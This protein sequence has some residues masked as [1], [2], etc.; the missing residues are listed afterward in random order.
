[1][2]LK[3][4]SWVASS[5]SIFGI[6]LNAYKIIWCWPTWCIANILW[7]YWSIRKKESAQILLWILFTLTNLFNEGIT[8]T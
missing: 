3:L 1:L 4:M 5:I 2:N 7:I 8:Q 6:I